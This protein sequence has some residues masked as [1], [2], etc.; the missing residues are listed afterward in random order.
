MEKK[1][2]IKRKKRKKY[3]TGRDQILV[4]RKIKNVFLWI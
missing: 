3:F 2:N 1:K 4:F